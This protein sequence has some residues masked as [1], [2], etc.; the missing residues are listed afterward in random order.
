M[1]QSV[2]NTLVIYVSGSQPTSFPIYK[3]FKDNS[4]IVAAVFDNARDQTIFM[5]L[6]KS[7]GQRLR[8]N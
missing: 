5:F 6:K 7:N 8:G 1:N 2:K 3:N 4:R